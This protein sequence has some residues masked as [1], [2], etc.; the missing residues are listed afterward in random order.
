MTNEERSRL[1]VLGKAIGLEALRE[2]PTLVQ[3]ETIL[4][5]HRRLVAR[6]FEEAHGVEVPE[7][8]ATSAQADLFDRKQ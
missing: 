3:P 6:W 2:L 7:H 8:R 1:A 4:A 5:W